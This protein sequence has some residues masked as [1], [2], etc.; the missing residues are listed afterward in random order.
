MDRLPIAEKIDIV[1]MYGYCDQNAQRA[2]AMYAARYP[3]RHHP[4]VRTVRRIVTLFKETGSVQP[5]VKRQPR[6]ATNDD[7]QVGVLAA[8]AA[9]PHISSRQIA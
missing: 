9:N 7:A 2:C 4:S 5:R 3:G 8:V 1:F 6:P